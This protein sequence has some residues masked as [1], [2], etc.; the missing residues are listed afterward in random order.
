MLEGLTVSENLD[1]S[2]V[3][4]RDIRVDE[5]GH[6]RFVLFLTSETEPRRVGR[7]IQRMSEVEINKSMSMLGFPLTR[8][9]LPEMA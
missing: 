6:Q 5:S 4:E 3:V 2:A 9:I 1:K 7:V 8:S